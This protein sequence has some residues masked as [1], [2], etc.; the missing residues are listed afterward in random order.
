MSAHT[1]K[2]GPAV[3]KNPELQVSQFA[4]K[5]LVNRLLVAKRLP[6]EVTITTS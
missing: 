6:P 1:L 4:L 5:F 3:E 2:T